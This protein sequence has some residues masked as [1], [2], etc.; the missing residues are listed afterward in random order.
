MKGDIE[1][2]NNSLTAG[3][4]LEIEKELF[5]HYVDSADAE[6]K[7]KETKSSLVTAIDSHSDLVPNVYEGKLDLYK[8]IQC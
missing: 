4:S 3:G 1:S 8:F 7:I 6:L 2:L 5:L